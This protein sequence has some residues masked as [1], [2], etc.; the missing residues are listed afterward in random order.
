MALINLLPTSKFGLRGK[1]GSLFESVTQKSTS[2]IHA[3]VKGNRLQSSQ[4]LV[5]GR[6]YGTGRDI[7]H[8]NPSLLSLKGATPSQYI[9]HLPK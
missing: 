3:L 2:N 1:P 5:K 6:T 7:V 4:D 8:V 9:N